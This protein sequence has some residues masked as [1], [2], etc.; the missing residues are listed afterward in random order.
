[1]KKYLISIFSVL[2]VVLYLKGNANPFRYPDADG[3]VI[4][5]PDGEKMKAII[6]SHGKPVEVVPIEL[7]DIITIECDKKSL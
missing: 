7:I 2:M 5:S 4:S 6:S 3:V 1:M